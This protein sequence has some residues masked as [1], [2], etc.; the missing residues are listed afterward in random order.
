MEEFTFVPEGK[1]ADQPSVPDIPLP[2]A[3]I[4]MPVSE[5]VVIQFHAL[6]VYEVPKAIEGVE[7]ETQDRVSLFAVAV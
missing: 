7:Y 1:Y 6:K 5:K 2:V 4:G 3:P